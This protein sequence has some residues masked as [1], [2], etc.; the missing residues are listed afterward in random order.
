MQKDNQ[1]NASDQTL[2]RNKYSGRSVMMMMNA[3]VHL[4][5]W[6]R[7][8]AAVPALSKTLTWRRV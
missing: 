1:E 5:L 7:I 3:H 6:L 4:L 8:R 2:F